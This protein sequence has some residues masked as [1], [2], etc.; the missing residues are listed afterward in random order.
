VAGDVA[1]PTDVAGAVG[2]F[3]AEFTADDARAIALEINNLI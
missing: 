1:V 2:F 3:V